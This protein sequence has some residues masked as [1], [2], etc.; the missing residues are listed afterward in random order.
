MTAPAVPDPSGSTNDRGESPG[1]GW[2]QKP[3][4]RR[5]AAIVGTI[6]VIVAMVWSISGLDVSWERLRGAPG[7][8]W[9]VVSRMFPPDFGTVIERGALGKVLESVYIAWIGTLIAAAA[10]LPMAFLAANNV[11]PRPVV[12]V[13]RVV[14]SV[15]RALPELIIAVV[16]LAVTGLGPWAGALAIGIGSIGTLGKLSSEVI[17]SIDGGPIEAVEASGG[18]WIS[19]MRWAVAPQVMP[20]IISHWL[21]RFEI[22]VRASAVLGL[23]GAGGIGGELVSQLNFRNFPQVGAVLLIVI[24][25][26]LLIDAVSSSVRRRIIAGGAPMPSRTTELLKDLFGRAGR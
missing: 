21:F 5:N 7:D 16:L 8:G 14:F 24:V 26:V 3:T 2:P 10:S 18:R 20:V 4:G 9:D 1:S 11:A 22:N 19:A 15:L 13:M 6:V 12:G 25:A 17:E 23:I